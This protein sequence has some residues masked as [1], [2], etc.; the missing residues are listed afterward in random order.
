M[1]PHAAGFDGDDRTLRKIL[2]LPCERFGA[3][4]TLFVGSDRHTAYDP[5]GGLSADDGNLSESLVERD[6]APTPEDA[7][8]NHPFL[9]AAPAAM[10]AISAPP[11]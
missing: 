9:G 2:G 6:D 1:N 3:H 8:T 11:A 7:H 10:A 5:A 4:R